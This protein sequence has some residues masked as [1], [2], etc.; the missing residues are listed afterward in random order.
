[1]TRHTRIWRVALGVA[2]LVVLGAMVVQLLPVYLR[3]L[4]FQRMLNELAAGERS[5]G[6]LRPEEMIRVEVVNTAAAMGLP[7]RADQVRVSRDG[8]RL[9][10]ETLYVV[11]V[12]FSLYTVDLHFRARAGP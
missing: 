9:R 11:P 4:Q 10:I 8:E 6:F 7:V 1:M 12:D 5:S 3:N 2:V